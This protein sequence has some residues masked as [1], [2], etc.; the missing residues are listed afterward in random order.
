MLRWAF[1]IHY[2]LTPCRV[3]ECVIGLGVEMDD[4]MPGL[5]LCLRR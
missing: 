2:A 5:A 1:T 4:Y 3:A